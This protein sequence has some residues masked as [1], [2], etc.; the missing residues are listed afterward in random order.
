MTESDLVHEE[1]VVR[2]EDLE[3]L[4]C[5]RRARDKTRCRNT[6]SPYVG[7]GRVVR[8]ALLDDGASPDPGCGLYLRRVFFLL[9]HDQDSRPDRL[10]REGTPG[11]AVDPR[12]V[13]P[14]RPAAKTPGSQSGSAAV[15]T[16]GQ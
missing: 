3:A 8:Y 2:R 11:E 4:D 12:T 15:E 16:S 7:D 6:K 9:S 10:Y 14:K 5:V 1:E 13:A